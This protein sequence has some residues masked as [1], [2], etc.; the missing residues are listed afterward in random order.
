V[1][2]FTS[3]PKGDGPSSIPEAD[4]RRC[5]EKSMS[6]QA[7]IWALELNQKIFSSHKQ[8]FRARMWWPA[9]PPFKTITCAP[10]E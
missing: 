10:G 7:L 6:F 5:P 4:V 3:S 8:M 1:A 9:V 2:M